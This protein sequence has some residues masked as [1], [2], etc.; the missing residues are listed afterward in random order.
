[1]LQTG[2]QLGVRAATIPLKPCDIRRIN[3]SPARS[4]QIKSNPSF[5]PGRCNSSFF[6]NNH[7]FWQAGWSRVDRSKHKAHHLHLPAA[8]HGYFEGAQHDRIN[9]YRVSQ[10]D[11]RL[12]SYS[13]TLEA[14]THSWMQADAMFGFSRCMLAS[15]RPASVFSHVLVNAVHSE[16][17]STS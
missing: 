15:E 16:G 8:A 7:S 10:A 9:R 6:S 2:N 1:M 13:A 3:H 17:S 11:T 4:N 5:F 14:T 12:V